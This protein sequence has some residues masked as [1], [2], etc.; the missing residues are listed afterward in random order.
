MELRLLKTGYTLVGLNWM[1]KPFRRPTYHLLWKS[2]K[3]ITPK[4]NFRICK[5]INILTSVWHAA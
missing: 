3:K 2:R 4:I 1:V 5:K